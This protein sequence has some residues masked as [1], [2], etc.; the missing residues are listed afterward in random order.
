MAPPTSP[1]TTKK[2]IL[3]PPTFIRRVLRL[4]TRINELAHEIDASQSAP[5]TDLF[6]EFL[7]SALLNLDSNVLIYGSFLANV[8]VEEAARLEPLRVANETALVGLR[9][10]RDADKKARAAAVRDEKKAAKQAILDADPSPTPQTSTTSTTSTTTYPPG[11]RLTKAGVPKKKSGPKPGSHRTPKEEK[12]EPTRAEI[13]Q[14][15]ARGVGQPEALALLAEHFASSPVR[16]LSPV[17]SKAIKEEEVES[18]GLK[19]KKGRTS[20]ITDAPTSD[21]SKAEMR[22]I[23][24]MKKS[25]LSK[26]TVVEEKDQPASSPPA[27]PMNEETEATHPSPAK[28]QKKS[29]EHRKEK[30]EKRKSDVSMKDATP[31]PSPVS[32]P[33]P[34]STSKSKSKKEKGRFADKFH[35]YKKTGKHDKPTPSKDANDVV[36]EVGNADAEVYETEDITAEVDEKMRRHRARIAKEDRARELGV[37][38]SEKHKRESLGT[39]GPSPRLSRGSIHNETLSAKKRKT[40]DGGGDVGV[41]GAVGVV[42]GKKGRSAEE[43]KRKKKR[44]EEKAVRKGRQAPVDGGGDVVMSGGGLS[45]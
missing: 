26:G 38:P 6:P 35:P 11:T 19:R 36:T 7:K 3:N 5:N 40:N 44:R 14:Q 29:K 27:Q 22:A 20:E 8:S 10:V 16:Q 43:E 9:A 39:A 32:T 1:A 33:I 12:V 15:R 41:V 17:K 34:T 45:E 2:A 28:K 30:K 4:A 21:E 31:I 13:E 42:G 37:N 25:R 24:K 18:A 23:K